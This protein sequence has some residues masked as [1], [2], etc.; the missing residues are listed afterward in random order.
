MWKIAQN[1]LFEITPLAC[2]LTPDLLYIF[3]HTYLLYFSTIF[4]FVFALYFCFA[5]PWFCRRFF[6]RCFFFFLGLFHDLVHELVH[7][8]CRLIFFMSCCMSCVPWCC[9]MVCIIMCSMPFCRCLAPRC[10]SSV[11][12]FNGDV[13]LYSCVSRQ[14]TGGR[15]KLWRCPSPPTSVEANFVLVYRVGL[16]MISLFSLVS[17]FFRVHDFRAF[18]FF[19]GVC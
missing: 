13:S 19:S 12:F 2:L 8:I 6:V 9:P 7:D 11:L 18:V 17:L 1:V 10:F 14:F 3:P 16:H 15:R 5:V 4:C